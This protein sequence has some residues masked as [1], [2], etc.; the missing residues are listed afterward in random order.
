MNKSG[1]ETLKE[2]AINENAKKEVLEKVFN[3]FFVKLNDSHSKENLSVKNIY[4]EIYRKTELIKQVL[5]QAE[6]SNK[7]EV[8]RNIDNLQS[9]LRFLNELNNNATYI[10]IPLNIINKN[11]TG[12]LYILKKKPGKKSIN[13][14]D[15]SLFISLD[16]VNLGQVDSLVNINKKNV[17]I[18]IRAESKEII[19]FIKK[20]YTALYNIL[21]E[22]GYK[23]IDIKYR[24]IEEKISILNLNNMKKHDKGRQRLD[25]RV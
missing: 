1:K 12:E 3:K 5:E 10:Q 7:A 20:N 23:L 11:H 14:N 25:L 6:F 8:L 24:V 19:N 21:S 4:K 9:N 22:K 13:I 15:V 2:E 16:T 17:S 18:N